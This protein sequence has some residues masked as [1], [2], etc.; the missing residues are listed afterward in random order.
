MA[1]VEMALL[2]VLDETVDRLGKQVEKDIPM[3]IDVRKKIVMQTRRILNDYDATLLNKT[4][5]VLEAVSREV[6]L[7]YTVQV[8]EDEILVEEQP[9]QVKLLRVG[10][11]GLYA[12]D[13]GCRPCLYLE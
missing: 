8:K 3:D 7:G 9:I 12:L 1:E 4:R 11:V 5:A 13:H 10:R 6:D 2:P